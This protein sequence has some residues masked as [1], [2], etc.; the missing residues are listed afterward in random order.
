MKPQHRKAKGRLLQQR[1]R[2]EILGTFPDL[3][4]RD[5]RSTSM[6]ASGV[7]LLLSEVAVERFPYSVECKRR[8]RIHVYDF[9]RDTND[10]VADN[11]HPLLVIQQDRSDPLAVITLQHFLELTKYASDRS[12]R[13]T[14]RDVSSEQCLPGQGTSS[15][16]RSR[17]ALLAPPRATTVRKNRGSRGEPLPSIAA[18]RTIRKGK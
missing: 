7:D 9:W 6:G 14:Q 2:D 12:N 4:D 1:V 8:A 18:E 5:V 16:N 3:T 15:S 11:T 10:N 17:V 13:R